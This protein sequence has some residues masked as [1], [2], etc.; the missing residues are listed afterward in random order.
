M[1]RI[2]IIDDE[3]SIRITL[4]EFLIRE[5]Y[6]VHLAENAE[7]AM[8]FLQ[9]FSFDVVL[10]DIILPRVNG[11]DLLKNIRQ[12][13]PLSKVIMMTGEPTVE[14]A[15]ESLRFGAFDYL[16]KPITKNK[17][18]KVV[19]NACRVI[20]LENDKRRLER[21]NATYQENLARLVE[22]RTEKLKKALEGII[23][24]SS[25]MVEMRDPY[26]AGHQLRVAKLAVAV[27]AEMSLSADELEGIRLAG[28]I[29][30]LGKISVPAEILVKPG[31]LTEIEYCMVKEHSKSGYDILKGIEFPW[32]IAR[33]VY[34][35]HERMD[36]SGYPSGLSGDEIIVGARILG[37]ADVVE[38]MVSHRPYRP[39]RSVAMAMAE[40]SSK[41]ERLYDPDVVDC[42][43][44]LF[45]EKR[46]GFD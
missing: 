26:T 29:H 43:R 16:T 45:N 27:A 35:H 4:R 5:S 32:P 40:I 28:V 15:A 30:D 38:S 20:A 19:R 9:R 18:L 2:L 11:V 31:A 14:T 3:K 24:A 25:K 21:E 17:I 1:I 22:E 44:R 36:G 13:S 39:A 41:R 23:H 46:F 6:E 42:C 7:A 33:M 10:T 8:M 37:V 34:Q 12:I